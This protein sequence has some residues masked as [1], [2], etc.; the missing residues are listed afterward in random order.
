MCQYV[1][2]RHSN[3]S[4]NTNNHSKIPQRNL[5]QSTL[6]KIKDKNDESTK[7]HLSITKHT[8]NTR[9]I[10]NDRNLQSHTVMNYNITKRNRHISLEVNKNKSIHKEIE[11][12]EHSPLNRN[13]LN[14][15]K[16]S[17]SKNRRALEYS[18]KVKQFN[19]GSH[20]VSKNKEKKEEKKIDDDLSNKV[21]LEYKKTNKKSRNN[22]ND[23]MSFKS[24]SIDRMLKTNSVLGANKT[25]YTY[26]FTMKMN[27]NKQSNKNNDTLHPSTKSNYTQMYLKKN[28]L[29]TIIDNKHIDLYGQLPQSSAR[30]K[31]KSPLMKGKI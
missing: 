2:N 15:K 18:I 4:I 8:M 17:V 19:M 9:N 25:T 14:G 12:E 26:G 7:R 11:F 24:G 13:V 1:L 10:N 6:S 29:R 3:F 23:N 16:N 27:D 21:I 30:D 20:S 28:F 31:R 22:N 5:F